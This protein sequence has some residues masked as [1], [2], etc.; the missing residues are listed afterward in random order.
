MYE[1]RTVCVEAL[2]RASGIIG[3][4]VCWECID[5]LSVNVRMNDDEAL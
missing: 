4:V 5:L 2:Q 1:I 3:C